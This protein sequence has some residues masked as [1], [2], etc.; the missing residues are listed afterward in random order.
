MKTLDKMTFKGLLATTMREK[1][2]GYIVNQI[3]SRYPSIQ[4][5]LDVTEDELLQIKGIGKV[6]ANQIVAALQLARMNPSSS[7][8]RFAIRSPQDAY[9]YLEDMKYLDREHF[10]VLGLNTKNEVM[11]K[12]TVFIGSLN[13]SIVHPRETYKHLIR[14]SCASALVAHNH[15]SGN[16]SPSHED[17]EVT[18]RLA[19]T[20]K[21]VGIELLDHIIIGSE[22]HVSL[23]EKGHI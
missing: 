9:T 20:G 14:R 3:F 5:L 1:E 16:P 13:A 12:E 19:E 18:K 7:V 21:V 10:V 11:F 15:P 22:K 6:K 4:E 2:D 23:K 17:I 8:E